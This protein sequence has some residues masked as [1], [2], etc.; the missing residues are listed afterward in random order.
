MMYKQKQSG[1]SLVETLV[2]ITILLI[3]IVGPMTIIS[4]SARSTS[5]SSEQVVAFFLAQEGVELMQKE[6]DEF[7][8]LYFR[9]EAANPTP[10]DDFKN[11]TVYNTCRRDGNNRGCGPYIGSGSNG[12]V[13][14]VACNDGPCV[15]YFNDSNGNVRTRYTPNF[16]S[17]YEDTPYRREVI[18]EETSAEQIRVLSTVYWRTGNLRDEQSVTV[19]S[20]LFNTYGE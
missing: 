3:V 7:F 12:L 13:E 5:F 14:V 15:L 10:W 16:Q 9:N 6:R 2:A 11:S 1:F 19:E 20:Y 18:L 8:N 4:Q 17:G